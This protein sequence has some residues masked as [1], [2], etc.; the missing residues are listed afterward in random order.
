MGFFFVFERVTI[1]NPIT[2]QAALFSTYLFIS[3]ETYRTLY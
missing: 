3:P 2:E 1:S